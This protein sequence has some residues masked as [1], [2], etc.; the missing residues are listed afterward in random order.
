MGAGLFMSLISGVL[1][2]A[3]AL[4]SPVIEAPAG[5]GTSMVRGLPVKP[6]DVEPD[7]TLLRREDVRVEQAEQ[8]AIARPQV[9][10]RDSA[11]KIAGSMNPEPDLFEPQ[12]ADPTDVLYAFSKNAAEVGTISAAHLWMVD[13]GTQTLRLV[14]A[15]GQRPPRGEPI[16]VQGSAIG[17]AIERGVA[18]LLS[19]ADRAGSDSHADTWRYVLPLAARPARGAAVLD[20]E[21]AEPDR[22]AL[23]RVAAHARSYLSASLAVHVSQTETA[24]AGA[25]LQAVAEIIRLVD[26]DAILNATLARAIELSAAHTGSIMLR[27]DESGVLHIRA[28]QGLPRDVARQTAVASGEGIAGW[29]FASGKPTVVEDLD[30]LGPRGRRHGIRSAAAVPVADE[31]GI[32]GVLNV[33][34]RTFH[35]RFSVTQ[36]DALESLGRVLAL[37]I[38]NARA[39]AASR[40]LYLETVKAL[41]LALETKDP[42]SKGATERVLRLATQLGDALGIRGTEL[43]GL[44]IAALVHDIGMAAAGDLHSLGD[45]PLSTVEWGMLKLHPVIAADV[46]DQAPSLRAAVPIVYH[47]HEHFDGSGYVQGLAGDDIPLGARVLA[48][49]DS[50]VAMT[51]PRAYRK[52]MT[53]EQA[54]DELVSGSGTQYDPKVVSALSEVLL[55]GRTS[56]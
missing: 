11:P 25:L 10:E 29:V 20:L 53:A 6:L 9:T 3:G 33:G 26:E 27:D 34:C 49:A 35:A 48:V 32:L 55:A 16:P 12:G 21:V 54:M 22:E 2:L 8:V 46:L 56:S 47:H 38:R 43:Q 41:A 52:A 36:L 17:D 51:S 18:L 7:P 15:I 14:A 24:A 39:H 23:T 30:D 50:Y 19:S 28:S 40:D 42:Y 4:R 31:E 13:D 37:A 44:R 45:R 5:L 1:A